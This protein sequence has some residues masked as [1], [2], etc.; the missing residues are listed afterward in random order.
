[1]S[2]NLVEKL[3]KWP[4]GTERGQVGQI[5]QSL[6]GAPKGFEAFC[7]YVVNIL[8]LNIFNNSKPNS[9]F[10][11]RIK[12]GC[13]SNSRARGANRNK[14]ALKTTFSK[15]LLSSFPIMYCLYF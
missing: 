8:T 7:N 1:M 6:R 14:R 12:Q 5:A 15:Y 2:H 13:W 3:G 11:E 9:K 10:V 4:G